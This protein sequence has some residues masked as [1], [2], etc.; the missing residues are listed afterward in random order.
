MTASAGCQERF[1][2]SLTRL[3]A[4]IKRLYILS[5]QYGK[6]VSAIGNYIS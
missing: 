5:K 4:A 2:E 1:L 3:G 6:E